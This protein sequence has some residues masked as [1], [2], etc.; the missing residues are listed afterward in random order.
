MLSGA[1]GADRRDERPIDAIGSG[2]YLSD[3]IED[4]EDEVVI[5]ATNGFLDH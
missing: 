1:V 3:R 5:D 4:A 2:H